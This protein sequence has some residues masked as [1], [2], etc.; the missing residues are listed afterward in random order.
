MILDLVP[1]LARGFFCGQIP[2]T[3]SYGQAA[4]FL[5]LGLQCL[6]IQA[7]VKM[8]DL[9]CNQVL[10]LLNKV[11]PLHSIAVLIGVFLRVTDSNF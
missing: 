6:D 10:A 8:L 9:P 7:T 2:A 5:C 4:I 11:M 1:P 3:M